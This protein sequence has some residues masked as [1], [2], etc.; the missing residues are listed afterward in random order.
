MNIKSIV[1]VVVVFMASLSLRA[2]SPYENYLLSGKPTHAMLMAT[3]A[4][5]KAEA[6][7]AALVA[8]QSDKAALGEL[9]KREITNISIFSRKLEEKDCFF[10]YFDYSG[11]KDYIGAVEDFEAVEAVKKLNDMIVPVPPAPDRG[12]HWLQLEWINFIHGSMSKAPAE[13]V[14]ANVT[15]IK[16]ESEKEYRWLHQTTWPGIVDWMN[17]F[18]WR[19]FSIFVTEF[20]GTIYEFYFTE[21]VKSDHPAKNIGKDPVLPRWLK[22]T[23]PCQNPLPDAK[24]VW[25]PMKLLK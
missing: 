7:S 21:T 17:R 20:N 13:S 8:L 25:A 14:S 6:L 22:N 10:V 15:R 4:E 1:L 9:Q 19:N 5:G 24:G 3:A 18:G 23:D 2:F 16:P 12:H 11:A